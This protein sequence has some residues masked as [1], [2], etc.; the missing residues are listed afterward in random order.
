MMTVNVFNYSA[1]LG[2]MPSLN[3]L[4]HLILKTPPRSK[5]FSAASRWRK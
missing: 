4:A 5:A 3:E 1:V 2:P